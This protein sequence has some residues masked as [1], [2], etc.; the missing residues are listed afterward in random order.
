M[1]VFLWLV[2]CVLWVCVCMCVYEDLCALWAF[3]FVE[4]IQYLSG[5]VHI[6]MRT[7]LRLRVRPSAPVC[8]CAREEVLMRLCQ[9]WLGLL[10]SFLMTPPG[11]LTVAVLSAQP[12]MWV[13]MTSQTC[14]LEE[15]RS[16][17]RCSRFF[18][19]FT[20]PSGILFRKKKKRKEGREKQKE[21]ER[22]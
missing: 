2:V 7:H 1:C 15:R 22:D 8:V 20:L 10:C 13:I 14:S 16:G 5:N 6:W 4:T 17:D 18:L 3:S 21:R 9:A 12:L 19:F 11:K